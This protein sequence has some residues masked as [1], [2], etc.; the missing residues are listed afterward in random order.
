MYSLYKY[1]IVYYL[2][3]ILTFKDIF[4]I[5]KI[6]VVSETEFIFFISCK[7]MGGW[8]LSSWARYTDLVSIGGQQDLAPFNKPSWVGAFLYSLTSDHNRFRFRNVLYFNILNISQIMK[9]PLW[10]SDRSFWLQI[11]RSWVRFPAL[12]D[13]L[14]SSGSGTGSTAS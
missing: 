1:Y 14:R 10:S 2:E 7:G 4:N 12:P 13:F 3:Y 9:P 11:Q 8:I 5:F 6:H